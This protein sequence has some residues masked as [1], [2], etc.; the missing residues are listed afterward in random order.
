M[1]QMVQVNGSSTS[2]II[3]RVFKPLLCKNHLSHFEQQVA[4][5]WCGSLPVFSI[6][7][8]QKCL[9]TFA[10]RKWLPSSMNTCKPFDSKKENFAIN[11]KGHCWL[12]VIHQFFPTESAT[13]EVR[14][15]NLTN[16]DKNWSRSLRS[17]TSSWNA[18]YRRQTWWSIWTSNST[19]MNGHKGL[20]KSLMIP[21]YTSMHD[22]IILQQLFVQILKISTT[23]LAYYLVMKRFAIKKKKCTKMHWRKVDMTMK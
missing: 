14:V 18:L 10:T 5:L 13:R 19:S 8:H 17:S 21:C 12:L 2:W 20:L 3:W 9:V 7:H 1:P 23:E 11:F 15:D 22:Q 6:D 4:F 16:S